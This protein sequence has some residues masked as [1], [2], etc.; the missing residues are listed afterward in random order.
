MA[1]NKIIKGRDL[2]LFDND[3]HSYAYATNHTLTITAETV[4]VSSKDHGVWGA[5]EVSKYSWE[6]TSENLFTSEDYDKLFDSMLASKAITVRFGLKTD[7]TDNTKNV[8]D[9]DTS[10]PYWTSQKTY[11]EGKVII[12]S[13]VANAN[14]GENATYSVTLTGTGSIKKT[15]T[16][17]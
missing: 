2:M 6:I 11:Y 9:G 8:A 5:S 13:L 15:T 16:P 12:T 4:D 1:A 3:G 14:N 10:L 17:E 7:Q